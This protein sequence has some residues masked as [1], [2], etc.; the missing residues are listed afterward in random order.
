MLAVVSVQVFQ[1]IVG[2]RVCNLRDEGR[3][4]Q[5]RLPVFWFIFASCLSTLFALAGTHCSSAQQAAIIEC[6]DDFADFGCAVNNCWVVATAERI[7]DTGL[8]AALADSVFP[9][10]QADYWKD[11]FVRFEGPHVGDFYVGKVH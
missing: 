8:Q 10:D 3:R 11:R 4:R 6:D 1:G 2:D 5:P 9:L 7:G